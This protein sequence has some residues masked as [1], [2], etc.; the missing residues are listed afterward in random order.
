VF[1]TL[2]I[3]LNLFECNSNNEEIDAVAKKEI[4][5][6]ESDLDYEEVKGRFLDVF[7]LRIMLD[8]G[9]NH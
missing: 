3:I 4:I 2:L 1:V 8:I 7:A 5:Y 6:F 9:M